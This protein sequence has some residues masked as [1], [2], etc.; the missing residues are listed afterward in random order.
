M[1]NEVLNAKS[2][3]IETFSE[4]MATASDADHEKSHLLESYGALLKATES[5]FM[6]FVC[7]QSN[8][9]FTQG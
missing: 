4:A 7:E 8:I 6:K 1:I 9:E 2:E 5:A 3:A